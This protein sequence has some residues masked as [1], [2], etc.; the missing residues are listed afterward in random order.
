MSD[1]LQQARDSQ[2]ATIEAHTGRSIADL[3][4]LLDSWGLSKHSEIVNRAKKELDIGHGH[5][6]LLAHLRK[7]AHAQRAGGAEDPLDRIYAG[8]KAGL[9]PLH[10]SLMKRL[11]VLGD[12]EVAPKQAYLSLRRAK[13]FATVGPGSRGRLEVGV[14]DKEAE[15]TDRLE[16]LPAGRMCSHRV[17]L[18]SDSE[19]DD[20][21]LG[22]L[23]AAYE[24]AG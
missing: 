20:E 7:E 19:I 1:R 12:F 14:N 18:T 17:H 24:R 9:R 2:I 8:N 13:Q 21:L 5:A 3:L 23:R 4:T 15:P 10:E 22:Y 6:N 16:R 11:E